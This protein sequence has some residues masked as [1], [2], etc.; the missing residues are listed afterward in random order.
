MTYEFTGKTEEEAIEN[1]INE[2]GLERDAFDVE[3][4]EKSKGIFRKGPVKIKVYI[5]EEL[6][7]TAM[8]KK[9]NEIKETKLSEI[10]NLKS[11]NIEGWSK[12]F[13][14]P[15]EIEKDYSKKMQTTLAEYLW[16]VLGTDGNPLLY[17]GVC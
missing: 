5:D 3:I 13:A 9:W 1:A 2:L 11:E 14:T 10:G 4:L 7:E 12:T 6:F 17:C 15:E 16:D 8:I